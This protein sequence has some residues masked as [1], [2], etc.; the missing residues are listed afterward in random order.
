MLS[1]DQEPLSL[2]WYLHPAGTVLG[3][4]FVPPH[5]MDEVHVPVTGAFDLEG[6]S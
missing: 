5:T 1:Q 4:W 6:E 2:Q 3:L